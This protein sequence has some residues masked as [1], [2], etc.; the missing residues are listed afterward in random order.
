MALALCPLGAAAQSVTVVMENGLSYK[1]GA[2]YV[3]SMTFEQVSQGSDLKVNSLGTDV[4]SGG[5]ATLTFDLS[6]GGKLVCDLY[7]PADTQYLHPGEYV[8]TNTNQG[9]RVDISSYSY[10][11]KEDARTALASGSLTVSNEQ[12]VYTI[13]VNITLADG[14]EV[15][16]RWSGTL[17]SATYSEY[18]DLVL[19]KARY[20][21]NPQE[22]GTFYISFSDPDYYIEMPLIFFSGA[23][24][25]TLMPGTYIVGGT[26][27]MTV[28]QGSRIH[29]SPQLQSRHHG[30]YR[31]R[32]EEWRQVCDGYESPLR[33]RSP[34]PLH[35]GCGD[36]GHPDFHGHFVGPGPE[37]SRR[38]HSQ[39]QPQIKTGTG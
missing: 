23:D 33:R 32:R 14:Q 31:H 37:A 5:N 36:N 4:Y 12:K 8:V 22:S 11:E 29:V 13:D 28:A 1:F 15:K 34:S 7:G 27:D 30:G 17:P 24:A 20:N 19:D 16:T 10:Y 18:F 25:T 38:R 35:I 6:D 39:Y 3:Q 26:G 21:E 2:D 9:N